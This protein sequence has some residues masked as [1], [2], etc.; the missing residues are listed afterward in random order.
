MPPSPGVKHAIGPRGS[1]QS[2]IR[3]PS[4]PVLGTSG[5]LATLYQLRQSSAANRPT[6]EIAAVQVL[7]S[8]AMVR[9]STAGVGTLFR[10]WKPRGVPFLVHA[11][12]QRIEAPGT[13]SFYST[14]EVSPRIPKPGRLAHDT[15]A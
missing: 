4:F 11:P 13:W 3:T 14:D 7:T 8:F 9:A 5:D 2:R 12:Y 15:P 1:L 6:I 10:G